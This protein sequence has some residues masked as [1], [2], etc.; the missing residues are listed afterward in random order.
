[1]LEEPTHRSPGTWVC[2]MTMSVEP[3]G[4]SMLV[5]LQ[6][7]RQC[8]Q[9]PIFPDTGVCSG[10]VTKQRTHAQWMW[11]EMVQCLAFTFNKRDWERT[12]HGSSP[13]N[14]QGTYELVPRITA[15]SGRLVNEKPRTRHI[16]LTN[17]G[18]QESACSKTGRVWDMHTSSVNFP[19][20]ARR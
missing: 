4:L 6:C 5:G 10:F 17:Q 8:M 15:A 11:L 16:R 19:E 3:S 2:L 12:Q 1:M 13:E 18:V 20:M 14:T 9:V 7:L